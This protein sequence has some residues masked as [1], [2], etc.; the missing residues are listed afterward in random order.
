MKGIFHRQRWIL[1]FKSLK[2]IQCGGPS[3]W[4]IIENYKIE[5]CHA[6]MQFSFMTISPPLADL[7]FA[8][9]GRSLPPTQ[10]T[11][12]EKGQDKWRKAMGFFFFFGNLHVDIKDN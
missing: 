3:L 7:I 10:L 4:K 12:I 2:H 1:I 9:E 11:S 5:L 8:C 6:P